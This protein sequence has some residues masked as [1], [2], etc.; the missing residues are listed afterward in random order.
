MKNAL[1][2]DFSHMTSNSRAIIISTNT[3]LIQIACSLDEMKFQ[4]TSTYYTHPRKIIM[5]NTTKSEER[6]VHYKFMHIG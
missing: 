3:Y 1:K 5:K 2:M 4:H 6:N